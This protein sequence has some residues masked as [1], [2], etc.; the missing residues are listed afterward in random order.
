MDSIR[1]GVRTGI[2]FFGFL[3]L[4]SV[5]VSFP[6]HPA[7]GATYEIGTCG[8]PS[9][10]VGVPRAYWDSFADYQGHLLSVDYTI[11]NHYGP[12]AMNV[13]VLGS[14]NTNG[15][16]LTTTTPVEMGHIY[17]GENAT[18]TLKLFVPSGTTAFKSSLFVVSRDYCG[19]VYDFPSPF[20]GEPEQFSERWVRPS[21]T[22]LDSQGLHIFAA[23][24][25]RFTNAVLADN[26]GNGI[27]DGWTGFT[28]NGSYSANY[29]VQQPTSATPGEQV[30][31]LTATGI[32]NGTDWFGLYMSHNY[33]DTKWALSSE[34][35]IEWL[36]GT[37]QE[38]KDAFFDLAASANGL[39]QPTGIVLQKSDIGTGWRR[40]YSNS[41]TFPANGTFFTQLRFQTTSQN[42]SSAAGGLEIRFRRPQLENTLSAKGFAFTTPAALS[43]DPG[44]TL[45]DAGEAVR[46]LGFA[47]VGH[48]HD[49]GEQGDSPVRLDTSKDWGMFVQWVPMLDAREIIPNDNEWQI[50]NIDN[51]WNAPMPVHNEIH[52]DIDGGNNFGDENRM[53]VFLWNAE[54]LA[55]DWII[56]SVNLNDYIRKGDV[57]RMAYWKTAGWHYAKLNVYRNGNLVIS[58][59]AGKQL[60]VSSDLGILKQ[61]TAG[62]DHREV[63]YGQTHS[64]NGVF[65]HVSV[66]EVTLNET[67]VDSF[68]NS[69][70]RAIGASTVMNWDY[71][72]GNDKVFLKRTI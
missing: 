16:I 53:F 8:Q 14:F 61:I 65:Q 33:P 3:L 28:G 46:E 12:D 48:S 56:D 43:I 71:S 20:P 11:A 15:V 22:Y 18:V 31:R 62:I 24:T 26:D 9:L 39:N 21:Q 64:A 69:G 19:S 6:I 40:L 44:V 68:M 42:W 29:S 7:Q 38:E 2:R 25:N 63:G 49:N 55:E 13:T 10:G 72:S 4:F 67:M 70:T 54:G 59:M 52:L 57:C 32:P 66:E 35:K 45:N 27:A 1:F 58:R 5:F 23:T 17:I 51:H 30:I 47:Q 60:V 37:T 36:P 41:M 34:I 50:L